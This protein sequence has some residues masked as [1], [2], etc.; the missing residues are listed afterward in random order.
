MVLKT[1]IN[2]ADGLIE[3]I[4]NSK[5]LFIF[6]PYVKLEA[7]KKLLSTTNNCKALVVRW[8]SRDLIFGASDLE[9]YKYCKERNIQVFRNSRLHL[10]AYVDQYKECLL[11]SANISSRALNI[12]ESSFYNYEL[13]TIVENLSFEDRLYFHII[14]NEA[15]LITDS[16]YEKI[17]AQFEDKKKEFPNEGDF[18]INISAP[19]K[20][21]LISSLPMSSSVKTLT[22]AYIEKKGL[23]EE[24]LNCAIHDLA[25]YNIPLSLTED[26]FNRCLK[27]SFFSHPFIKAFIQIVRFN[28]GEIYF[29]E[30]KA[31]IQSNCTN[32]PIPR[33]WEITE[34][35]QILFKWIVELGDGYYK[36][37]IPGSHSERLSFL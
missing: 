4:T 16:I 8:E 32:V 34:N 30:A 33:R 7:L 15:T 37:D 29:G 35:I 2:L 12:P 17:K 22:R 1:G 5:E 26:K 21:F 23:N 28:N 6:V 19:D 18:K 14:L 11:G 27:E 3:F 10:K 13:A 36:V 20:D 9:V 24:E 25:I 31:W